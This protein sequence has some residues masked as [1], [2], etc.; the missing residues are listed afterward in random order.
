MFKDQFQGRLLRQAQRNAELISQNRTLVVLKAATGPGFN[1]A[2]V[3]AILLE[4]KDL[5]GDNGVFNLAIQQRLDTLTK[6]LNSIIEEIESIKEL[7]VTLP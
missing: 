6:N 4:M 7:E 2:D 1:R 3:Q 5:I